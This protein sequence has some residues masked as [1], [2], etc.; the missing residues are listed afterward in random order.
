MECSPVKVLLVDD[1]EDEFIV[2]RDLLAD[3]NRKAYTLDWVSR[4]DE[5]RAAILSG[6]WDVCLVDYRLGAHTG[7]ELM[8]EVLRLGCTSPLILLTGQGTREIDLAAMQA[9]AA[10]YL[11]KGQFSASELER[12]IRYAISAAQTMERLRVSEE[13]YALAARAANDG[14]WDWNLL[15]GE[16]YFAP[17]WTDM[18]GFAEGEIGRHVDEWFSRVHPDDL[19]HLRAEINAHL[20]GETPQFQS[21]YRMTHRDGGWVWLLCRGLVVRDAQGQACRMAGSQTDITARKKAEEKLRHDAHHDSLTGLPNRAVFLDRLARSVSRARRRDDY[22]FAVLFLDVDRF[23]LVNDSSGHR[24]GDQLLMAVARRL[25][26]ALR[27]G[28]MVARHGGDEFTIL[29]DHLR[30]QHDVETIVQR[31][32]RHLSGPFDICGEELVINASIGITLS[33]VACHDPEQMLRDADIAMYRAKARGRGRYEFFSSDMHQDIVSTLRVES[34]LRSAIKNEEFLAHYQ[35]IVSFERGRI[36]GFEA[37]IR[38][39]HPQRGLIPPGQFIPVAEESGLINQVGRWILREAS[40]QMNEWHQRFASLPPLTIS[41]NLST[42]QFSQP[43]LI[44]RINAVLAET[45]LRPESLKIEITESAVMENAE[46]AVEM[47]N[48]LKALG[49][50]LSIDDF[51][52]GYS[53][54]NYLHRFPIDTLKIDRSFISRMDL[55]PEN[56]EIVRTI[57]ALAHNLGMKVVAE[58]I[59]TPAQ[60]NRL[61]DLDCEYGQG[62]YLARPMDSAAAENF[63]AAPPR[64]LWL[65]DHELDQQYSIIAQ[66]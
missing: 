23:K 55:Q 3:I 47:L 17:R 44:E 54:F 11:V 30:D 61:R 33:S 6:A 48:Q 4:Y 7:L 25:E 57:I 27:P 20:E 13:R 32:E 37:L 51:G 12:S 24:T 28:D 59:E 64:H 52:T 41:I 66:A 65:P 31:I 38:W 26:N 16:A 34:D 60:M 10:D 58:G 49:V 40:R 39:R 53:S 1:D 15:T 21:E 22:L 56:V 42:R 46:S 50:Q 43:D 5:A 9:G 36:S 35:P 29:L 2:T 8:R 18:L 14:L 63:I 19:A 45:G 62:Y